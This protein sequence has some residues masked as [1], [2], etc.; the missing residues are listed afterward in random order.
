MLIGL[1]VGLAGGVE[2]G[3]NGVDAA[4]FYLLVYVVAA[5]GTFATLAYLSSAG[6]PE[7]NNLDQLSGLSRRNPLAS[8][9]LA[10][11]MLSLSG[12]PPLAGFWGKL[13]L[14]TSAVGCAAASSGP[15]S[16]WFFALAVIAAINA[17]I[18]AAYYLKVVATLYF[19]K[20]ETPA[21]RRARFRGTARGTALSAGFCAVLVIAAGIMPGRLLGLAAQVGQ[22]ARYEGATTMVFKWAHVRSPTDGQI[23]TTHPAQ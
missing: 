19:G 2:T 17:A 11:F 9:L 6:T 23:A 18:A 8:A 16:V 12:V 14:F 1:T 5:L 22:S 21:P 13:T 10:I 7:V 4:L 15:T 20:P 3:Y